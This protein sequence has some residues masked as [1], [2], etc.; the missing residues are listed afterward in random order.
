M[1]CN[2]VVRWW[3]IR[4]AAC[5]RRGASAPCA[6]VSNRWAPV[7]QTRTAHGHNPTW[8]SRGAGRQRVAVRTRLADRYAYQDRQRVRG[9]RERVRS[10]RDVGLCRARCQRSAVLAEIDAG[11][12]DAR[13]LWCR[14]EVKA[15]ERVEHGQDV[16]EVNN[17]VAAAG[18]VFGLNPSVS[19]SAFAWLSVIPGRRSGNGRGSTW[20]GTDSVALGPPRAWPQFWTQNG[21]MLAARP[22]RDRATRRLAARPRGDFRSFAL[23]RPAV[24]GNGTAHAK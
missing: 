3:L 24:G 6:L 11:S 12:C 7:L 18:T 8:N 17:V 13:G 21:G 2:C 9:F 4:G 23:A 19:A 20:R 1:T 16:R 15:G 10:A 14:A 22:A 5:E